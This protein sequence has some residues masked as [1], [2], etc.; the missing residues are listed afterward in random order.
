MDIND[1]RLRP[2]ARLG[3]DYLDAV[4]ETRKL[5]F[6]RNRRALPEARVTGVDA[7]KKPYADELVSVLGVS[8]SEGGSPVYMKRPHLFCVSEKQERPRPWA[9]L[10]SEVESLDIIE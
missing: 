10:L 2:F 1:E 5:F 9:L 4:G 8:G 6:D 3:E 7:N